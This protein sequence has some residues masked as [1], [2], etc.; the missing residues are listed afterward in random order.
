MGPPPADGGLLLRPSHEP[1]VAGI[2][3]FYYWSMVDALKV[4]A[5]ANALL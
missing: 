1:Y 4:V 3:P 5:L 2:R